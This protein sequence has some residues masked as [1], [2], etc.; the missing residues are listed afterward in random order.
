MNRTTRHMLIGLIAA[1]TAVLC[2]SLYRGMTEPVELDYSGKDAELIAEAPFGGKSKYYFNLL[3]DT[4]KHA[5]NNILNEIENFPVRVEVPDLDESGLNNVFEAV[6]YDNP[7]LFFLDRK[8]SL[9]RIGRSS[10]FYPQYGFTSGEYEAQLAEFSAETRSAL[11]Q[12]DGVTDDFEKELILHEWLL[13]KSA[14]GENETFSEGT[15]YGAIVMGTA[16][17]EGYAKAMKYLLEEA[18]VECYVICGTSEN[19]GSGIQNHMWNIVRIWGDYYHLD[20][21]WDDPV[22]DDGMPIQRYAYFNVT[23]AYISATHT[24]YHKLDPC[25]EEKAN[26]YVKNN[27]Y[28]EAY[29]DAARAR[30]TDLIVETANAGKDQFEVRFAS[31]ERLA[32]AMKKMYEDDDIYDLLDEADK[33]TAASLNTSQT[34]R[35]VNDRLGTIKIIFMMDK[36]ADNL[37][38]A[39]GG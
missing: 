39:V 21:T 17:C 33:R 1:V 26:Y 15:A 35:V 16:S 12:I 4:E 7:A 27:M 5:Y 23:D 25:T 29:D 24:D 38:F 19:G 31:A 2:V 9:K 14:Y 36:A 22:V 3:T 32:E 30:I 20:P 13:D 8:C 18:E 28:F 34:S 6:F 37:Q 10:Y 11:A